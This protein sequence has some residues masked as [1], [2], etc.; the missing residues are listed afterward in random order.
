MHR[1]QNELSAMDLNIV[2][3]PRVP[4]LPVVYSGDVIFELPPYHSSLSSLAAR[5]L[6]GMDKRY[7]GHPWCK[8][9]TTN[10]YNVDNLKFCKSYCVGH[11]VCENPNCD[12]LNRASKKNDTE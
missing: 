10:I 1:F 5:N 2:K 8:V 4:F 12:Y 11:L 6:E 7:D 9:L 3:K